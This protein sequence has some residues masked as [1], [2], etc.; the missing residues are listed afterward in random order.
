MPSAKSTHKKVDP[1]TTNVPVTPMSAEILETKKSKATKTTPVT[2][3]PVTT[4][5]VTAKKE[6]K[7]RTKKTDVV[8]T[9]ST[10]MTDTVVPDEAKNVV[11]SDATETSITDNFSEFILK[12][13]SVMGQF[14]ALKTELKNLE[15]KT[16]KQLKI[17][18]KLNNK[19]KRKATR[20]PSGFVKPSLISNELA[21]FL[22]KPE[23]SEMARTDVTREINKYIRAN[24]LQDKE[25][26]RKINPDQILTTLL[27]IPDDISL[28]YFNLQ[29][30]MGPH[31]PKQSKAVLPVEAVAPVAPA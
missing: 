26:G 21:K 24:N 27:K 9:P 23:G 10:L 17:V 30:Y 7:H 12:F 15:K 3:T 11:V 29:R 14:S 28:T 5:P 25:N 31:F 20:A 2:T 19:K 18:Q 13:Q 6:T 1:N 22:G 16:V 8:V 4:T